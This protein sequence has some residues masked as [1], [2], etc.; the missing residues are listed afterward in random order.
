M[1]NDAR[2]AGRSNEA[3]ARMEVDFDALYARDEP[4]WSGEPNGALIDEI[5]DAEP[6][7]ALDVGCGEGA[8]AVWLA[9]RGWQVTALD[10]A[11]AALERAE[12]HAV[13]AGVDVRWLHRGLLEAR[14]ESESFDLVS[15]Q[16]PALLHT[17][18]DAAIRA[19]LSLV[20][21]GGTLL[22][23]HHADI[24][25][26]EARAHGFDPSLYVSPEDVRL[27]LDENWD[28]LVNER[29]PRNIRGGAGAHHS[30]DLVLKARRRAGA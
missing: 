4:V 3:P 24:D 15:A 5:A 30:H 8:D 16:Y 22:V 19:L 10:V 26:D 2:E 14:L 12:Q 13:E 1:R 11:A 25:V 6:G 7:R 9:Q 21:P 23:V 20:A 18:G 29:R 17:A 27:S 28:V